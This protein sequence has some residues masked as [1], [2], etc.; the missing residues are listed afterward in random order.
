VDL[1]IHSDNSQIASCGGDKVPFLWD[2][3]TGAVI[4]KFKGH[5][6]NINCIKFGSSESILATGAYDKTIKIWDCRSRMFDPIQTLNDARDSVTSVCIGQYEI[7]SGS[8]DEKV[9]TYDIRRGQLK[10]DTIGH[11]VTS[12]RLTRDEKLLLVSTL[13]STVRLFDRYDGKL[14]VSYTGHRNKDYPIQSLFDNSDATVFS[15]SEDGCFYWWN[16][17]NGKLLLAKKSHSARLVSL[18]YHPSENYLVTASSDETIKL[19]CKV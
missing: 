13:D 10:T 15:G 14:L 12:V 7:I 1:D 11:P 5:D 17:E 6:S 4:R 8:L 19:W 2:V 3:Q 9:R 18:D 16:C